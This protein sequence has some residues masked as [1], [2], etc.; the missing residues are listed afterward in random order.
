MLRYDR[1][2]EASQSGSDKGG[3]SVLA[4]DAADVDSATIEA[5]A[6]D[7]SGDWLVMVYM[8]E[9][10]SC[11]EYAP[12]WESVVDGLQGMMGVGRVNMRVSKGL[13]KKSGR[14]PRAVVRQ[15]RPPPPHPR[16]V[17]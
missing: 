4:S 8:D 3:A 11:V 6:R 2:L 1:V 17:P 7:K 15:R 10:W 16:H 9:D 14:Q 5:W 13:G 12:A